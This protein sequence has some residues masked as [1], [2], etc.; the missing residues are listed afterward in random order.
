MEYSKN[1]IRYRIRST[2]VECVFLFSLNDLG[3]KRARSTRQNTVN[4]KN[5]F[6]AKF[7]L[8]SDL[9]FSFKEHRYMYRIK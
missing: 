7:W 4:C 2:H 9:C 3:K 5:V 6:V 8:G 1:K